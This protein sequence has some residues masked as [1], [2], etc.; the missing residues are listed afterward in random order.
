MMVGE[1]KVS[2]G[3]S[4]PPNG[5]D[6]GKIRALNSPHIY[7][8]PK[9]FSVS[10]RYYGRALSSFTAEAIYAGSDMILTLFPNEAFSKSPT[11][12]AIR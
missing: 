12:K 6:G 1:R 10:S 7:G 11:A 9:Y 2:I 5:N 3:F 8:T 4:I